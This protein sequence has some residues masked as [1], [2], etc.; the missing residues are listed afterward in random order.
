MYE[1]KE[2]ER[3][4]E[5]APLRYA[6]EYTGEKL[7]DREKHP[8]PTLPCNCGNSIERGILA[9]CHVELPFEDPPKLA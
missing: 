8:S 7:L 5:S 3:E 6:R 1:S 9:E 2:T 4:I